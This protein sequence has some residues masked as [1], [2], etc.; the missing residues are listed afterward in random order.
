MKP[1]LKNRQRFFRGMTLIE[2]TAASAVLAVAL[3]GV[4]GAHTAS[5]TRLA[6]A[7]RE[8]EASALAQE[9]AGLLGSLPYNTAPGGLLE[10]VTTANDA[11]PTDLAGAWDH[12]KVTKPLSMGLADH[13]E[14]ELIAAGFGATLTPIDA[15]TFQSPGPLAYTR[16]WNVAPIM[17]PATPGVVRGVL[18]AAMVR[19]RVD[20][21]FRHVSVLTMRFDPLLFRE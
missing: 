11:D 1:A 9:L 18:V 16:F 13:E 12:S 4:V 5:S 7:N 3:L 10:N 8:A 21:R 6:Q 15:T 2:V 20:G 19:Y 17:D 14:A